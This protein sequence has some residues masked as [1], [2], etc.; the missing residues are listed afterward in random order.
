MSAVR[1]R[2]LVIGLCVMAALCTGAAVSAQRGGGRGG[3]GGEG[4]NPKQSRLDLLATAFALDGEQ[5]SQMKTIFEDAYKEAMPT[6]TALIEGHAAIAAAIQAKKGQPAIDDAVREYARHAADMTAREVS[7]MAA[8]MKLLTP[9]QRTKTTGMVV[10]QN[11]LHG[12]FMDGK[13]DG[14][15]GGKKY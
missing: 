13:W 14:V 4:G 15:P 10:A 2:Q 8:A 11:M 9:E 1:S 12:M 5:K 3:G 7:A 6:R